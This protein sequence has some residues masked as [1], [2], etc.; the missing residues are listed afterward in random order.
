VSWEKHVGSG[1]SST[2]TGYLRGVYSGNMMNNFL[3][4]CTPLA[5]LACIVGCSKLEETRQRPGISAGKVLAT[6]DKV[7]ITEGE[8]E[9]ARLGF[10]PS[11]RHPRD[12]SASSTTSLTVNSSMPRP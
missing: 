5:I 10:R 2:L 9:F 11:C 7:K 4:L 6:V 1:T 3:R 12:G 8:L